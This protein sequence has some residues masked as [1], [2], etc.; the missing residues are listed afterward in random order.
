MNYPPR[1]IRK[2]T[3]SDDLVGEQ[4]ALGGSLR[5]CLPSR[6]GA[7]GFKIVAFRSE[8]V[9]LWSASRLRK[10][11]GGHRRQT[12]THRLTPTARLPHLRS[13]TER[14]GDSPAA[15]APIPI[16]RTSSATDVMHLRASRPLPRTDCQPSFAATRPTDQCGTGRTAD[17]LPP[18]R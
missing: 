10:L 12:H 18:G 9:N 2:C 8:A 14:K 6:P 11:P 15:M 4:A 1:T 16:A 17:G 13:E 7:P 5:L 3:N